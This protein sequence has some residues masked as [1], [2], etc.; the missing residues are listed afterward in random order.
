MG[1]SD[2]PRSI[3]IVGAGAAGLSA[4]E[5]LRSAGFAG[6]ITLVG[7]E[8]DEPY[9][10]PPL[11][12]QVL[13][14]SWDIERA[15]LLSARRRDS[16][17]AEWLLGRKAVSLDLEGRTVTL[18]DDSKLGFEALVIASGVQPRTLPG[19]DLEGVYTLRTSGDALALKS[20]LVPGARLVVVGAGF[21]GLEVAATGRG[22]GADVTIVEPLE[23]PLAARLG[24]HAAERLLRLHEASGVRLLTA[25][26]VKSLHG[27][28]RPS[29][30]A[31]R[32]ARVTSV[33]L[34]DGTVLDADVVLVAIGCVPSVHWLMDSGLTLD[35]GIVC[36]ERCRAAP[37]VW[38]AGDV[39]R[40]RHVVLG[41]HIRLEHRMNATDQGQ[42]A[43]RSTLGDPT[44]F[45]PIPFFG[46]DHYDQRLQLWGVIPDD[47]DVE[48]SDGE[49]DGDSFV[50]TFRRP[51]GGALVG[52]VGWNAA[53]RLRGYRNQ[54]EAD[55]KL[56]AT[57]VL[58]TG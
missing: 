54:I 53:R 22:L 17:G 43:A 40:W 33:E 57:S 34:G 32:P 20:E 18:L 58:A 36:D 47:A 2:V 46:T 9:D 8:V 10:R 49:V 1:E 38:A 41:R 14:G 19:A 39:A 26:T 25:T 6:P 28:E 29:A 37:G 48:I 7:D 3:L 50:V 23:R 5:A 16:L 4:A 24:D 52:A 35:D 11:S 55:W 27:D 31:D 30:G 51:D 45:S 15:R 42:A 44:P 13:K 21:L 12:K 56:A